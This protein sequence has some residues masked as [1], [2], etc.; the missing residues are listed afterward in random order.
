MELQT[1]LEVDYKEWFDWEPRM[2]VLELQQ[3]NL[4]WEFR[5]QKLQKM[6]LERHFVVEGLMEFGRTK[7]E[8]S[9]NVREYR[10]A[11]F[12]AVCFPVP[13]GDLV[14]AVEVVVLLDVERRTLNGHNERWS[15]FGS[16]YF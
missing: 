15:L 1:I 14:H 10:S 9:Y 12:V 3:K 5:G 16:V 8:N 2:L 4:G 7:F 6:G 11:I 13:W